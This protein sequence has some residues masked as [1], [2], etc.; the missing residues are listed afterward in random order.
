MVSIGIA[1]N[2]QYRC[3]REYPHEIEKRQRGGMW[4]QISEYEKYQEMP[5]AI[6][7]D[8]ERAITAKRDVES[9]FPS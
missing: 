1:D 8:F 9:V 6:L 5:S 2:E 7:R 3:S 4:R